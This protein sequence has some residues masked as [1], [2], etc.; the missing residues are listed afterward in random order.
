MPDSDDNAVGY[1]RTPKGKAVYGELKNCLRLGKGQ[2]R[3]GFTV[4]QLA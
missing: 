4:S 2:R 1:G 3:H